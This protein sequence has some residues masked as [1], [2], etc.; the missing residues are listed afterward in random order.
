M[1]SVSSVP[2][3]LSCP[4]QQ[5]V[6]YDTLKDFTF[7]AKLVGSEIGVVVRKDS[8]WKTFNEFIQYA[9]ANPGKIKYGTSNPRGSLEFP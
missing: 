5:D 3:F 6:N 2:V 9:K 4:A 8:P 1:I 7:I